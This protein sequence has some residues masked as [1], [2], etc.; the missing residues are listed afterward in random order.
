M[1]HGGLAVTLAEMVSTAGGVDASVD[2]LA[3]LFEETPGRAVVETTA[4]ERVRERFADVAPVAEVGSATADG[5]LRLDV[6][7]ESL[8]YGHETISDLRDVLT[9]GLD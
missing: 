8:S 2:S 9:R 5:T 7:G 6:G 1:S 4:P 3:A